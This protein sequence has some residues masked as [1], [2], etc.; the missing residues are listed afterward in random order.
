MGAGHSSI[1]DSL[2]TDESLLLDC[3][4]SATH[5]LPR[6]ASDSVE[7]SPTFPAGLP[8][9]D[10]NGHSLVPGIL[11]QCLRDLAESLPGYRASLDALAEATHRLLAGFRQWACS[12]RLVVFR[13]LGP[14]GQGADMAVGEHGD[15]CYYPSLD[16]TSHGLVAL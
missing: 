14:V 8:P 1:W 12:L 5:R 16:D 3:L 6:L 2:A 11:L 15:I 13:D 7:L 4:V 10:N 9:L